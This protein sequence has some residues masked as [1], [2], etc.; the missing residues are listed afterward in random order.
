DTT[1]TITRNAA[2][3]ILTISARGDS[4]EIDKLIDIVKEGEK[5]GAN[6]NLKLNASG[7]MDVKADTNNK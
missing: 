2:N 3:K 5:A 7:Q 1:I 6:V 4:K